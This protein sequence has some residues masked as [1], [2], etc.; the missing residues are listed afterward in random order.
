VILLRDTTI[1]GAKIR[2]K[3]ICS[4]IAT[5]PIQIDGIRVDITV[6][7]GVAGYHQRSQ[8]SKN[9]LINLAD[10]AMYQSKRDGRN[11]VSVQEESD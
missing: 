9:Q 4:E 8:V 10:K 5:T 3:A 6:S 7:V 11:Q 2:A 1:D